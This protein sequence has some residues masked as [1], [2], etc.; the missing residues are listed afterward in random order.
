M[1]GRGSLTIEMVRYEAGSVSP[2][3]VHPIGLE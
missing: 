3:V 2:V 1:R